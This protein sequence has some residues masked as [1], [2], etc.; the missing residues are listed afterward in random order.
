MNYGHTSDFNK[1]T[2]FNQGH[3]DSW[4]KDNNGNEIRFHKPSVSGY[5]N[6]I[7]QMDE[8]LDFYNLNAEDIVHEESYF[9]DGTTFGE[10]SKMY[11]GL[12]SGNIY[13]EKEWRNNEVR[14]SWICNKEFYCVA[15]RPL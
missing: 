10:F 13:I 15:I 14:V 9:P 5:T 6:S 8:V 12:K 2:I 11:S 4:I 7:N 3:L 1:R